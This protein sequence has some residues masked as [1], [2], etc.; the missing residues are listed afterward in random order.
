MSPAGWVCC[1]PASTRSASRW[2]ARHSRTTTTPCGVSTADATPRPSQIRDNRQRLADSLFEIVTDRNALAAIEH[3]AAHTPNTARRPRT[4]RQAPT[5]ATM[6]TRAATAMPTRAATA[7]PGTTDTAMPGTTD[8]AMP[9][10]TDTAMPGT[11]DTA[12][13]TGAATA[14]TATAR[15]HTPTTTANALG[16]ARM[17][18]RG[19][20]S[21]A[22][23]PRRTRR[24]ARSIAGDPPTHPTRS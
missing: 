18:V 14:I 22:T 17:A 19:P 24:A 2:C 4:P 6:P 11:T 23:S 13:P 8:T 5:G 21:K 1:T 15:T 16:A 9:G 12:M 20:A 3:P 7:M 10:T